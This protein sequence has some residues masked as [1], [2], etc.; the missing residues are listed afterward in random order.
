[1]KCC[2]YWLVLRWYYHVAF[3]V[4]RLGECCLDSEG[5]TQSLKWADRSIFMSLEHK[6]R[7]RVESSRNQS[8]FGV[9]IMHDILDDPFRHFLSIPSTMP[10][11]PTRNASQN[12]KNSIAEVYKASTRG[13][14]PATRGA[15]T[16]VS[17]A[18]RDKV[19]ELEEGACC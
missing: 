3:I 4:S 18:D 7:L 5:P 14:R 9:L 1:M 11:R 12:A 10:P 17:H 15:A 6:K 8:S 13:R 2:D 19:I 16:V